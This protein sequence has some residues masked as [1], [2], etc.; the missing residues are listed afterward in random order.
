MDHHPGA[1]AAVSPPPVGPDATILT[2]YKYEIKC[3]EC[4]KIYTDTVLYQK[5]YVELHLRLDI[6]YTCPLCYENF[7][8][9]S[10]YLGHYRGHFARDEF[11]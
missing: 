10:R 4:N 3:A 9:H 6:V 2:D 11:E 5:H 8:D 1:A 7:D